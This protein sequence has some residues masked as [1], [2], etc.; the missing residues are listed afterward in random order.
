M[1]RNRSSK[2]FT[3]L[4][5]LTLLG[6]GCNMPRGSQE[7]PTPNVTEAY[8]TVEARLT[9]AAPL[10]TT[11]TS[12][13]PTASPEITQTTRVVTPTLTLAPSPTSQ[14]PVN[15]CNIAG[16]G[17]PID[18]TIPDNTQM[19]PGQAFTKTWRLQNAGTC[20]WSKEYTIALFSG[21]GM[22]SPTSVS[23]PSEVVPGVTVDISVDMVAP[24][25]A[26]TYQGNWKLRNEAGEW[27]GI[28]PSGGSPFWVKI[29]VL[30]GSGTPTSETPTATSTSGPGV[31]A[32]GTIILTPSD[33]FNL[34][35]HRINSGSGDD[36]AY[37]QDGDGKLFLE[38]LNGALLSAWGTSQPSYND[39]QSAALGGG[40]LPMESMHQGNF[41]CYRTD[42]GLTGWILLYGFNNQGSKL[43]IQ[44][45][46]WAAP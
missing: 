8:Q 3:F 46:T 17:N 45:L 18:V 42:L 16:A 28:G 39:C 21:A 19:S 26:G 31:Q 13:S 1:K 43:T 34:D 25:E 2:W 40:S 35:N 30:G 11:T 20:T 38:P 7:T 27:F 24:L 12:A 14:K 10:A 23:M 32:S 36:L 33:N 15:T 41:L 5:L 44:F 9:Q 4:I 6:A 29:V 22:S 37:G